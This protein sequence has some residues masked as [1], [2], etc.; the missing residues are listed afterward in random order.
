[1]AIRLLRADVLVRQLEAQL[2]LAAEQVNAGEANPQLLD[3]IRLNVEA[4]RRALHADNA[5]LLSLPLPMAED[6]DRFLEKLRRA[7]RVLAASAP[8]VRSAT[9]AP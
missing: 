9:T 3:E 4:L 6:A 8:A 1:V 7:P 2:Q 5:W